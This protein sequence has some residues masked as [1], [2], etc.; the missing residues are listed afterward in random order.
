[1]LPIEQMYADMRPLLRSARPEDALPALR[2]VVGSFP[3]FADAHHDL[4]L[5]YY[6][7]EDKPKALGHFERAAELDPENPTYL[8]SLA[9][10]YHV[11]LSRVEEAVA[12]YSR[13]LAIRPH[14]VA[15]RLTAAHLQVSL[16]RFADAAVHYRKVLDIEPWNSEAAANLEKIQEILAGGSGGCGA[17][18]MHAEAHRLA[19]SGDTAAARRRLEQL[20]AAHPEFALAHNDLGVLYYQAG[21]KERSLPHYERAVQL[22]PDHPT[23]QKNL[24]DF[25]WMEQGRTEEAMR[26]YVRVLKQNPADI[27]IL[28]AV[29]RVCEALS[30]PA[31]ARGFYERILDIEPW[32]DDAQTALRRLDASC[33]ESTAVTPQR[34]YE[35]ATR[36]IAGGDT[37]GGRNRLQQLIA[38]HPEFA[39]AYND[40][41]VLAYQAGDKT[42]ALEHYRKAVE[43]DS[44][45]MTFLKN[46]AD[47][48]WV[49]FGKYEEA[50]KIYVDVLSAYP[51]DL[52][53]L[54]ATGKLCLSLG[55]PDDARVFFERVRQIEPWNLEAGHELERLA[56]ASNAA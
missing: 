53:T 52:E 42:D 36:L 49:G 55:R 25:Y 37:A 47:C 40:L 46:L 34:V 28:S 18:E 14:D 45:N 7:S 50:L 23:F 33:Q 20:I 38:A 39:V 1:M 41:G 9:D 24:A 16:Q 6:R 26:L 8:N 15:V 54:L 2:S 31:D 5:L 30:Q 4:G 56:A 13:I 43:L 19:Q 10:Y 11:E 48:C 12:L 22:E 35:E 21:E 32:N 17:E 44:S 29:A 3:Q 51:E 27:E